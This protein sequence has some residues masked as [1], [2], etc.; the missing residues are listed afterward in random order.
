[1]D[2]RP[3]G[4]VI[5]PVQTV[6]QHPSDTGM[7]LGNLQIAEDR[8]LSY[9]AV[10]KTEQIR[11]MAFVTNGQFAY[12]L[13]PRHTSLWF[14]SC[15]LL[16]GRAGFEAICSPAPSMDQ[17]SRGGVHLPASHR[18]FSP[19]AVASEPHPQVLCVFPPVLSTPDLRGGGDIPGYLAQSAVQLDCVPVPDF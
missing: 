3:A 4:C 10:L 19:L 8:I 14:C 12:A 17:W 15:I 1:M 6:N 13:V 2:G 11:H 18:S 5:S 16:R 7:I 9:A